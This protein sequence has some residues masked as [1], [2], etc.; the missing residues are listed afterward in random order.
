M[1]KGGSKEVTAVKKGLM[2]E[3]GLLS[4]DMASSDP[5]MLPSAMSRSMSPPASMSMTPAS[6]KGCKDSGYHICHIVAGGPC[7]F[8]DH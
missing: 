1:K 5:G 2:W 7:H 3:A 6:T 8:R 4:R